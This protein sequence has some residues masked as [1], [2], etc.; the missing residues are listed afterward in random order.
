MKHTVRDA[1]LEKDT[2]FFAMFC[3]GPN[4][5]GSFQPIAG[6][7]LATAIPSSLGASPCLPLGPTQ[8][9]LHSDKPSAKLQNQG[10]FE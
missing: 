5:S 9:I 1:L 7:K 8:N 6:F 4:P 10:E 3:N 2:G